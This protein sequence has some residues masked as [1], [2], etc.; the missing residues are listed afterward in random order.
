[1]RAIKTLSN[2]LLAGLALLIPALRNL[3]RTAMWA[4]VIPVVG[5]I[6][7]L[8]SHEG[9]GVA[10]MVLRGVDEGLMLLGALV[11]LVGS[12]RGWWVLIGARRDA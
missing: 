5:A 10:N 11:V 6:L 7:V 4:G 12:V 9:Y 8:I 1:M 3:T 2:G